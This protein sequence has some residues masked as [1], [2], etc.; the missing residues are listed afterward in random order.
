MYDAS[1]LLIGVSS[2]KEA[3][4]CAGSVLGPSQRT[5]VSNYRV[6]H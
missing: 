5:E 1:Q 4:A 3:I 2:M 6:L